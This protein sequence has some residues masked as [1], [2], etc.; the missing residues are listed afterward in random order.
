MRGEFFKLTVTAILAGVLLCLPLAAADMQTGYTFVS[1]EQNVTHTKL[2]N[3]VNNGTILPAFYTAKSATTALGTSDLLLIY[4]SSAAAFRK[5]L[6]S[7]ALYGNRGIIT[8]QVV[9]AT[10]DDDDKILT[11]DVSAETLKQATLRAAVFEND[12][13][14][15]G[16]TNWNTPA[17]NNFYLGYDGAWNKTARSN[18][19][20]EFWKYRTA[21]FTNLAEHLAPVG[22]DKL[23]LHSAATGTNRYIEVDNLYSNATY[24]TG[25]LAPTDVFPVVSGGEVKTAPVHALSNLVANVS[26]NFVR[27]S[28]F[29][30]TTG[31][32]NLAAGLV[33]DE[34][35]GLGGTPSIVQVVLKCVTADVGYSIGDELRALYGDRESSTLTIPVS[36]GANETNV[37]ASIFDDTPFNLPTKSTGAPAA[38]TSTRWRIK[39]VAIKF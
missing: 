27:G 22:N 28:L 13:L 21:D 33:I 32:S 14:I 12:A 18:L 8:N 20:Y 17:G 3:Q 9:D 24:V 10:P 2:N 4:S 31:E 37:F 34:A 36:W 30:Y 25:Q 23:V 38:A 35:H 39:A 19:W 15:N 26:S 6:A 11:Y 29:K 1:G 7:D 5:I 16:R